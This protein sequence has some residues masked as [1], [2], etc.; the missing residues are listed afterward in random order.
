[1]EASDRR[2]DT[3]DAVVDRKKRELFVRVSKEKEMAGKS[4]SFLS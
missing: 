3:R 2:K 4:G 1:L